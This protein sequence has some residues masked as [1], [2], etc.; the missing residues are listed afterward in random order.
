MKSY[1]LI[2]KLN[3]KLET[4]HDSIRVANRDD[5]NGSRATCSVKAAVRYFHRFCNGSG[6]MSRNV[7]EGRLAS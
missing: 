4:F 3:I 6:A 7:S 2:S 5:S 1:H